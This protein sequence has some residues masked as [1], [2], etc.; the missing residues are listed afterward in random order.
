MKQT[1]GFSTYSDKALVSKSGH[2]GEQIQMVSTV[3]GNIIDFVEATRIIHNLSELQ[4]LI[5]NEIKRRGIKE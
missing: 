5:K 1:N 2:L 3:P 4:D